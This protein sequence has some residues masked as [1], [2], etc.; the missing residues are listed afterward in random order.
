[1]YLLN[2]PWPGFKV[3]YEDSKNWPLLYSANNGRI[4]GPFKIWE[5]DYPSNIIARE[6]FVRLD[7]EYAEFDDLEFSK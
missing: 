7:G 5:I 1:M 6:E 2:K 3:V 4:F